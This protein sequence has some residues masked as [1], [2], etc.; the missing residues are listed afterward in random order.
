MNV[1]DMKVEDLGSAEKVVITKDSTTI[2]N[3]NSDLQQLENHIK[4]LKSQIEREESDYAKKNLQKRYGK[5]TSC[6]AVIKVGAMTET[7][8]KEKKLRIEDALNATRAAVSEGVVLG[9]G[10]ALMDAFKALSKNISHNN[11]DVQR[12]IRCVFDVIQKPLW[13]IAENA[14]FDGNEVVDNQMA[15]EEGVGFNAETGEWV[16]LLEIGI[17]DPTKV[18]RSVL[19]NAASI[20][21]VF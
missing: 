3:G 17:L 4:T 18:T 5:L 6:V 15:A 14:G 16:D 2:I 11:H 12:G 19:L 1:K 20:A 7:E 9:G 21:S 8:A 13:Q 10:Y